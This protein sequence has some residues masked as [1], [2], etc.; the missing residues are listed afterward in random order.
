MR[1][2]GITLSG[3]GQALGVAYGQSW[4]PAAGGPLKATLKPV[5]LIELE[6]ALVIEQKFEYNRYFAPITIRIFCRRAGPAGSTPTGYP[7]GSHPAGSIVINAR[8]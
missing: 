7:N 5:F 3:Q 2:G 8:K 4:T 6:K 1:V